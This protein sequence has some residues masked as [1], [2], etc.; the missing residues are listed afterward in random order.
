MDILVVLIRL[1]VAP[2]ASGWTIRERA[3]VEVFDVGRCEAQEGRVTQ[4]EFRGVEVA[5]FRLNVEGPTNRWR[6]P[7]SGVV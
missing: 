2:E 7:G 3:E 5:L 4:K 6:R 1:V